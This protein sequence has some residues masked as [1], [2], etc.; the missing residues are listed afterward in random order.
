MRIL[1]VD[2]DEAGRLMLEALLS[3]HGHD[4]VTA[5]DGVEALEVAQEAPF[6]LVVTDILMPRMDGYQL[7]RE[8]KKDEALRHAPFVFYTATYTDQADERFALGLGADHFLRKPMEPDEF[9]GRIEDFLEKVRNGTVTSREAP[10]TGEVAVLKEYNERLVHKLEEKLVDLEQANTALNAAFEAL[11]EQM[12]AKS[13]VVDSLTADIAEREHAELELREAN[14]MLE[15]IISASPLAIVVRDTDEIVRVWNVAAERMFRWTAEEVIG[16]PY[17]LVPEDEMDELELFEH[18]ISKGEHL[19]GVETV[20]QRK[21]GSRVHVAVSAARL[22]D[23]GADR[24]G[25]VAVIA[26]ISERRRLEQLKTEFVS[27]VSHELRTPLTAIIGYGDLI[28]GSD[29]MDNQTARTLV[30]RIRTQ[31]SQ[32][33]V[34]VEDLLNVL[35][36]KAGAVELDLRLVNI[37]DFV[38]DQAG[39][40]IMGDKHGLV[41]DVGPDL[42]EITVDPDLLGLALRNVV[43]NAVKYSPDGGEVRVTARAANGRITIAVTDHGVGITPEDIPFVF[44]LFTQADM[45]TTRQFGGLGMGLYLTRTVVEAHGGSITLTSEVGQGS[46]FTI[47]LP[48]RLA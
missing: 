30:E 7:C 8:W 21:D 38:A 16:K 15:T 24:G 23:A 43:G 41:L 37:G 39:S 5:H 2:D 13:R 36:M 46:T 6:D 29:E 3:G 22:G 33:R 32:L 26:D 45:S 12:E 1:V 35:Q 4:V 18:A 20:R 10:H 28:A 34:L 14:D 47:E 48:A 42:P 40:V 9:V 11:G 19:A 44:E 31:G 17:P 25:I 27:M